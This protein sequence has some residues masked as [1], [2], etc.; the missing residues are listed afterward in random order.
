MTRTR[1]QPE[2]VN[3]IA[4]AREVADGVAETVALDKARGARFIKTPE[5]ANKRLSSIEA[6]HY[7]GAICDRALW[8]AHRFRADYLTGE[9]LASSR[10]TIYARIGFEDSDEDVMDRAIEAR[11]TLHRVRATMTRDQALLAD[12]LCGREETTP[13]L[14]SAAR[15]ANL[16]H[17]LLRAADWYDAHDSRE[18][19]DPA[20]AS[21][22]AY[23]EVEG[24]RILARIF[25]PRMP[26]RTFRELWEST[27]MKEKHDK[28]TRRQWAGL[29]RADRVLGRVNRIDSEAAARD[30]FEQVAAR[31]NLRNSRW[32]N[33]SGGEKKPYREAAA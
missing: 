4:T 24:W 33:L 16:D 6:L 15:A 25:A 22:L 28:A 30:R 3:D 2:N 1:H 26:D 18:R 29:S 31:H 7:R 11:I 20:D 17:G 9:T 21:V 19:V 8:A 13:G 12:A 27:G 23:V 14:E 5:G 10:C 32:D